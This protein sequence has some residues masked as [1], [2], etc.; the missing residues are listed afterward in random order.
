[1]P[2]KPFKP[3]DINKR[4]GETKTTK[5]DHSEE[6]KASFGE[7]N[8]VYATIPYGGARRSVNCTVNAPELQRGISEQK[9][10]FAKRIQ[11]HQEYKRVP[12][13][14]RRLKHTLPMEE[15]Y[16]EDG[17]VKLSRPSTETTRREH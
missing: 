16:L 14:E 6:R 13:G 4:S 2:P 3:I 1:M 8:T 5:I 9:A 17:D 10:S 7:Q 11:D 15:E 12:K